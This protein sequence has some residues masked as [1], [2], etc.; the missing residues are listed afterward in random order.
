MF[1]HNSQDV[2]QRY[3][4][5]NFMKKVQN[6]CELKV[7]SRLLD[8]ILVKKIPSYFIGVGISKNKDGVLELQVS[9]NNKEAKD[10][11]PKLIPNEIKEHNI[12]VKIDS[13]PS[14]CSI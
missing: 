14:F 6:I 7:A 9:V 12:R 4:G 2:M 1:K 8:K 11:I 13:F 3:S 10:L 5:L